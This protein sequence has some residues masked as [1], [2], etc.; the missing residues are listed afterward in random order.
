MNT[1]SL[2]APIALFTFKRPEYTR[3]TL[4]SLAQ[5]AAFLESPL[6]IYCDGVRT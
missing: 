5:N 4:E 2:N 3:R 1:H 6:F